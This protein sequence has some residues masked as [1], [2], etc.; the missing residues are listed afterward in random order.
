MGKRKKYHSLCA[1]STL[2][3]LTS[4]NGCW[5]LPTIFHCLQQRV[6]KVSCGLIQG[7]SSQ[8]L[9]LDLLA[10]T[11]KAYVQS[12]TAGNLQ[13][14]FKV[15]GIYPLDRSA[16]APSDTCSSIFRLIFGVS[17]SRHAISAIFLTIPVLFQTKVI[18]PAIRG[19]CCAST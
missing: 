12:M 8:S 11:S 5:L 1:T 15:A 19:V 16:I 2:L 14:A 17:V 7:K 10:V 13:A 18:C 6:P 3:T 4:A 9:T